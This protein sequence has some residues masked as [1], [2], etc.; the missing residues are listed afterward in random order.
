MREL[1]ISEV[2]L[3]KR[4]HNFS[5]NNPQVI[6]ANSARKNA[7]F[8]IHPQDPQFPQKAFI[9]NYAQMVNI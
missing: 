5:K 3:K 8:P 7:Y 6:R 1:I 4:F 9:K 2:K